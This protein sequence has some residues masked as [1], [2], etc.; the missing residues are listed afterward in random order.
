M[1]AQP[2]CFRRYSRLLP[3]FTLC[4]LTQCVAGLLAVVVRC[5]ETRSFGLLTR[6]HDVAVQAT[7][8]CVVGVTPSVTPLRW[9]L[10][11]EVSALS[12]HCPQLPFSRARTS[13]RRAHL[14]ISQGVNGL[15]LFGNHCHRIA[16]TRRTQLG[17]RRFSLFSLAPAVNCNDVRA[18][19]NESRMSRSA[20]GA[21]GS[22]RR[23]G[24]PRPSQPTHS[25]QRPS[26]CR[27][28][29]ARPA[30]RPGR[31]TAPSSRRPCHRAQVVPPRAPPRAPQAGRG[32]PPCARYLTGA[33]GQETCP[34]HFPAP[35]APSADSRQPN[36]AP[37]GPLRP[38]R[39]PSLRP[40]CLSA[41]PAPASWPGRPVAGGNPPDG[42]SARPSFLPAPCGPP[43]RPSGLRPA[44]PPPEGILHPLAAQRVALE[45][46][47]DRR[48]ACRLKAQV[49]LHHGKS[50]FTGGPLLHLFRHS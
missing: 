43:A 24:R 26:P 23:L 19:A 22:I 7:R 11:M 28:P 4:H 44:L 14:C 13:F 15:R 34:P 27:P 18:L 29:P 25:L 10:V 50:R 42:R 36:P 46:Q 40:A 37:A 12:C 48:E 3:A 32:R 21:V 45:P 5:G 16:F 30:G 38:E 35:A 20:E 2:C 17:E 6:L 47:A 31:A 1:L 49:G 33:A 41:R 9:F 8:S 39:P